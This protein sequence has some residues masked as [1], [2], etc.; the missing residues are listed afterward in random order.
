MLEDESGRVRLVGER[1][2]DSAGSFVTGTIIAALGAETA[3]GDFEVLEF[4]HSGL[5][6]QPSRS[7]KPRESSYVALISN[8]QMGS[9]TSASELRTEMLLEWM[10]GE[11]GN[12]ED[13]RQKV[14]KITKIILA[15]NSLAQID[16]SLE[17]SK[18]PVSATIYISAYTIADVTFWS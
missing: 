17:D 4:C 5:P 13:D 11:L 2:V 7:L 15:G 9:T 18:K 8:L 12:N 14:R 10:L 6:P 16:I 1:V 3:E